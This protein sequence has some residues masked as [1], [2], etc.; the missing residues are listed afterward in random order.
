MVMH[1]KWEV[2]VATENRQPPPQRDGG[3]LFPHEFGWI[4]GKRSQGWNGGR[5]QA[6]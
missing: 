3:S 6:Q 4:D 2:Y 5:G 1:G